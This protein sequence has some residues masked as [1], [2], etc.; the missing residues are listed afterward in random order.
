M[1][2]VI[3]G[4]PICVM[5]QPDLNTNTNIRLKCPQGDLEETEKEEDSGQFSNDN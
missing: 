3:N 1:S 2:A 5:P 4:R